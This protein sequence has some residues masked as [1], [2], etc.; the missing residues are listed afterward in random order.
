MVAGQGT[1]PPAPAQTPP[2]GHPAYGYPQ[3][4]PGYGYPQQPPQPAPYGP[5][6]QPGPYGALGSTPPYGP[7][8]HGQIPAAPEPPRRDSRS[9]ALLVG[10]ALI[11]AL[12]AG[13]SVYALMNGGGDTSDDKAVSDPSTS[14]PATS[15]PTTPGPD[16]TTARPSTSASAS[17]SS[18]GAI[19]ADYLGTWTTTITNADGDNT[20]SLTI[21]Q[22]EVGDTV[23]SLVADGPTSSGS[24]HCVF[25][26]QLTAAPGSGG[27]LE[28]GPSTVTSGDA[29]YCKPGDPT[30][31]TLLP[32]GSL[33]RENTSNGEKLTYTKQ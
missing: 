12:G 6:Q 22:G 27:S 16:P 32:D 17:A 1:P 11:V 23:M 24:Y 7:P 19:P 5:P 13:G 18:D 28:L 8:Y 14:A 33:R 15:G 20:R 26:A 31:I 9:T 4:Q 25:Q 10:V 30:E 29:G 3:Q 21:Q 2:S